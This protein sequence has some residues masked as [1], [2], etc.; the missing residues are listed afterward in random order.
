MHACMCACVHACERACACA[1][2]TPP[3]LKR[4]LF[5]HDRLPADDARC[6]D[7]CERLVSRAV[8]LQASV[9]FWFMALVSV[10]HAW[11]RH[12][13]AVVCDGMMNA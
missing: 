4:A 12:D 3:H 8:Q 13:H 1:R 2:S 10:C 7:V 9:L 5:L 6:H 11:R